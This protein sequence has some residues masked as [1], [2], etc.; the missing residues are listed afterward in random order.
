VIQKQK[1]VI[2]R[3]PSGEVMA[4][5]QGIHYFTIGQSRGL[6][7][8]HHEKL[9]VIKIDPVTKEVWVG[10]EKYLF[11]NQM[12]I[13]NVSWIT[14]YERLDEPLTIKIRSTHK[15]AIGRL[16]K[17]HDQENVYIVKFDEPQRAITPGQAAVFYHGNQLLGGGWIL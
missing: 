11:N 15:G 6:G 10:D 7:M 17:S 13:S 5:H 14:Q 12:K 8:S 1:G 16:S 3:Y 2:R 9:F 4:Q